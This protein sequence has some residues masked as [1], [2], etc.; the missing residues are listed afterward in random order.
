MSSDIVSLMTALVEVLGVVTICTL[1]SVIAVLLSYLMLS[2]HRKPKTKPLTREVIKTEKKRLNKLLKSDHG[3][4]IIQLAD[5]RYDVILQELVKS[6][7][8]DKSLIELSKLPKKERAT[9]YVEPI[10]ANHYIN[11]TRPHPPTKPPPKPYTRGGLYGA[12]RLKPNYGNKIILRGYPLLEKLDNSDYVRMHEG[13]GVSLDGKYSY[14]KNVLSQNY[15]V[16][17]LSIPF[18]ITTASYKTTIGIE[19]L[20]DIVAVIESDIVAELKADA[21]RA[22]HMEQDKEK[23]NLKMSTPPASVDG[24]DYHSP[25]VPIKT[26][27]RTKTDAQSAILA[28]LRADVARVKADVERIR[29]RAGHKPAQ[30]TYEEEIRRM[31]RLAGCDPKPVGPPCTSTGPR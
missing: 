15:E 19:E 20:E 28:G 30:Q 18:D 7:K 3:A 2:A 13:F 1:M 8:R 16:F 4:A 14:E 6:H 11:R 26:T 12:D 31:K 25:Y 5:P 17:D 21:M 10:G 23:L 24:L 27:K 9:K 29:R 22:W